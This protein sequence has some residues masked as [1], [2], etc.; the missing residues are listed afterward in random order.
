MGEDKGN[1]TNKAS[2]SDIAAEISL[3]FNEMFIFTSFKRTN[4]I[5]ISF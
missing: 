5:S 3:I 4:I 2:R 1:Q